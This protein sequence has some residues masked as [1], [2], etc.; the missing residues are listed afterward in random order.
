MLSKQAPELNAI[1]QSQCQTPRQGTA[2][3]L[4]WLYSSKHIVFLMPGKDNS[5]DCERV[6]VCEYTCALEYKVLGERLII[7]IT[8]GPGR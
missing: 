3:V 1:P 5:R 8:T 6:G 4:A 2:I 7:H